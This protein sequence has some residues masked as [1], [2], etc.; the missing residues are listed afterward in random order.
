MGRP[1][2]AQRAKSVP[3]NVGSVPLVAAA[4]CPHPPLLVPEVAAGA[5]GEL[6]TL[7]AACRAAVAGL[8]SADRVVVVG[9][10]PEAAR[11]EK[12][13]G[14][15]LAPWGLPMTIGDASGNLPLSLV[16]GCWLAPHADAYVAVAADTATEECAKLGAELVE[17]DRVGLLI[18]GD[19]SARRTEK[20][21]GYLDERA[22]PFDEQVA[23]ALASADREAL[24]ALDPDLAAELMV[25][26]RAAWQVLAGTQ[27]TEDAELLYHDAPY[28]VGYLVAS[29]R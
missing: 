18:M 5:A 21:P 13:A 1:R 15:S 16:I 19:G 3:D 8:A 20:A 12:P 24:L 25:A 27:G 17:R 9:T 22:L 29:W 11:Y 23:R 26:G 2:G 6:D 10:A 28:G 7:R 4:V 14:G